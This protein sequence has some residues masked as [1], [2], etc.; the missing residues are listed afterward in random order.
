ME[1]LGDLMS[2]AAALTLALGCT[3]T[4]WLVIAAKTQAVPLYSS[5]GGLQLVGVHEFDELSARMNGS[6][7]N[8]TWDG[9]GRFRQ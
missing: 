5:D 8:S 2:Y 4:I 9:G 6:L 3:A 7:G 1:S